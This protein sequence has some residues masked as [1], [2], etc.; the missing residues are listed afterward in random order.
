VEALAKLA[1]HYG[2]VALPEPRDPFEAIVWENC[3]YLVD[4]N[5]RAEVY[6]RLRDTIGLEPPGCSRRDTNAPHVR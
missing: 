4:D 2:D 6:R 5:R 1:A 3:G